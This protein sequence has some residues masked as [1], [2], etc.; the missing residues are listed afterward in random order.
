MYQ[1]K[2]DSDV[3][4]FSISITK[5]IQKHSIRIDI[6]TEYDEHIDELIIERGETKYYA[7]SP[8]DLLMLEIETKQDELSDEELDHLYN[9]AE[10][11][12]GKTAPEFAEVKIFVDGQ[13]FKGFVKNTRETK[14][15]PK[16]RTTGVSINIG[17]IAVAAGSADSSNE[18]ASV[19]Y[20][21]SCKVAFMGK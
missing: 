15:F 17:Q 6:G 13:P 8:Y 7:Q 5:E 16:P 2:D 21:G 3:T 12:D 14:R 19:S 11:A 1:N 9:R 4:I 10:E 18:K 20:T